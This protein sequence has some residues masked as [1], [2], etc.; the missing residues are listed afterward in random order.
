M[1]PTSCCCKLKLEE[2]TEH[3][4]GAVLEFFAS[5]QSESHNPESSEV[6]EKQLRE[7]GWGVFDG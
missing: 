6:D 4:L 7:F 1:R 3:T 2:V 5:S